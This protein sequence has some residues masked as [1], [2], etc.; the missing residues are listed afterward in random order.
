MTE[1]IESA[2]DG[3]DERDLRDY[4][5]SHFLLAFLWLRDDDLKKKLVGEVLR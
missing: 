5:Q 3:K 1:G 2:V 4:A